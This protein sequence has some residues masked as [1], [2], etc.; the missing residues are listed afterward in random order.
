[1]LLI[2]HK[3][4]SIVIALVVISITGCKKYLDKKPDKA[5]ATIESVAELQ[6]LMDNQG[7]HSFSSQSSDEISSDN[8]YLTDERWT[9]LS[10]EFNKR[11]YLWEKDRLFKPGSGE[12]YNAYRSIYYSNTVLDNI[13]RVRENGGN[14][15]E[16]NFLKGQALFMRGVQHFRVAV[17]WANAFDPATADT[18]LGI[19]FRSS[20]DFNEPSV[21]GTLKQTLEH[22]VQDFKDAIPLLPL[23]AHPLRASKPAGYGMLSRVYLYLRQFD[24]AKLYADSCLQLRNQLLD[25]N[26]L[27]KTS[28]TPFA[29]YGIS[30]PEIIWEFAGLRD[31]PV[32]GTTR[33]I[34]DSLLYQ[35]YD[36][37]DLRKT[38]FFRPGTLTGY[39]FKGTYDEGVGGLFSGVA[40]D[41]VYLNRAEANARLGD[42][43]A[44]LDDLN[45][46]MIK[47][48]NNAV[49][50]V[51]I[52]ATDANDALVKILI[53]RRKELLFRNLR[54]M[55]IKRLNIEGA[56]IT[57]KRIING[58]TYMLPPND[59][60]F[61][62]PIP[63]DIISLSGMP[64]NPR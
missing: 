19:P 1:M 46:L 15:D 7:V 34:I 44:A 35:S 50:Y 24:K 57:L 18:D 56:N 14:P 64:Q 52:T 16:L 60:R 62:L 28:N 9:S 54:W 30:H 53:E 25:F 5:L 61:A 58:Q 33:G 27:S 38:I 22:I 3:S 26:T 42:K 13:G 47:R 2:H 11:M 51:P 59:L 29:P 32:A 31:S 37:N 6:S 39:V 63:E 41:E 8:Y 21:R 45:T 23:T 12:W 17:L 49:T 40:V 4:I 20:S 36:A 43:D 10:N 55:D 48:W